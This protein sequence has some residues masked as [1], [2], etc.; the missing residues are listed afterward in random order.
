MR[1][2]L[3][4]SEHG[5]KYIRIASGDTLRLL[6]APNATTI[7]TSVIEVFIPNGQTYADFY[8]QGVSGITGSVTVT[9]SNPDFTEGTTTMNVVQPVLA[10]QS[11]PTLTNAA[12]DDIPFV[13]YTGLLD[14]GGTYITE[15]QYVSAA[16]PVR[17]QIT[18][19]I[20]GVGRLVTAAQQGGS[21]V[22]DVPVNSY[23]SPGSVGTGGVAFDPVSSGTTTVSVTAIGFTTYS[24]SSQAVTVNP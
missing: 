8:V 19:S 24:G 13:V 20:P 14:T 1:A 2:S 18:S 17:A 6:I 11:L 16:G 21:V 15:W 5:G 23:Y 9:A 12:A 4:A 7:G 3:D 10:I 22:V